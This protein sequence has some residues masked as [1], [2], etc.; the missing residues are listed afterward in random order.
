MSNAPNAKTMIHVI[1]WPVL[2]SMSVSLRD[3]MIGAGG[4]ASDDVVRR[5]VF[6]WIDADAYVYACW[7]A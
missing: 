3:Q 5:A 4:S 1:M 7:R 6:H 2:V